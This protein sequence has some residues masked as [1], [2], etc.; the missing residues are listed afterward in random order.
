MDFS[1]YDLNQLYEA[2]EYLDRAQYPDRAKEI[3]SRIN[4]IESSD[5]HKAQVQQALD[6]QRILNQKLIAKNK[7][8]GATLISIGVLQQLFALLT[9]MDYG[10]FYLYLFDFD[11]IVIAA[12]DSP[13]SVEFISY[14]MSI[15][16]IAGGIGAILKKP[17]LAFVALIPLTMLT[18]IIIVGPFHWYIQPVL[19]LSFYLSIFSLKIGIQ[20]VGAMLLAGYL[21]FCKAII[22]NE[23]ID[24]T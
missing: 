18:F 2:L 11:L 20:M 10:R 22:Q 12:Q 4:A 5:G 16:F 6:N 7:V 19:S 17:K 15:A 3:E 1:K 13:S 21:L 9:A 24:N 8:V 14:L 23:H